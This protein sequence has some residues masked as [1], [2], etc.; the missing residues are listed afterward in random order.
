MDNTKNQSGSN[1]YQKVV[2]VIISCGIALGLAYFISKVAFDE[3]LNKVDIISTPNEK[4]RLVSRIS[5]DILQ[6]DQVQRAQVLNQKDYSGFVNESD[7][8]LQSLDTLKS[9]YSINSLQSKRI[10]SIRIL[11]NERDKLF[12]SYIQVRKN[13]VDNQA[14]SNQI[15]NIS[16]L[17]Q[18]VPKS[19][20]IITTEKKITT[21]TIES[22]TEVDNRGFF[23]KLFGVKSKPE[24]NEQIDVPQTV[25]EELN[26]KIDTIKSERYEN[27]EARIDQAIQDLEAKQRQK[28]A[29]FVN[30]ETELTL[31]GNILVSDMF[32][33]LHEVE[34]E[35]MHQM[36]AENS[37]ARTVVNQSVR[38][39]SFILLSFFLISA[40]LIYFILTDLRKGTNYR[41]ALENAK[42]AAEYHGAAKQRFLSNMSHELRTPLQSIIGY[43]EQLNF[44]NKDSDK[45]NVIY[46]SSQHLLQIVNEVLDY[47]RINSGKFNFQKEVINLQDLADEVATAMRPQ[48]KQKNIELNLSTR[49]SGNGLV[50]GDAFRLKQIL[51]N[52]VGNAIKFTDKGEVLLQITS[53][54]YGENT[55]IN[56]RIQDTGSGIQPED[57]DKI[58]DE[59]EQST[60]SDS[61]THFGN[62]LGLSIVKTLVKAMNGQIEVKSVLDK[63]S[64]FTVTFSLPT[65]SVDQITS[66]TLP[67]LKPASSFK[68]TV[69]LIDDDSFILDLCHSILSKYGIDHKCFQS[70]KEALHY[71]HN[72][73]LSHIF[74]DM[75]MP[76]INGKDLYKKLREKYDGSVKIIAFTAQALPEERKDIL[77]FGFDGLLLKPFKEANLLGALGVLAPSNEITL[78]E[79]QRP[80]DTFDGMNEDWIIDLFTNDTQKDLKELHDSFHANNFNKS[81]LLVHRM[82]GRTAQMGG[83]HIAFKLRKMEIDLRNGESLALPQIIEIDKLLQQFIL[84]IHKKEMS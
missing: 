51:F 6:I 73:K 76:E 17:I 45:I 5:R 40:V 63:G 29:T 48:A 25:H 84:D 67:A 4:L 60:K 78:N 9:L 28:S 22:S 14:F 69:W 23:A 8:I 72:Q 65:S 34:Q 44:A 10:D 81:E 70:P 68:D 59:F 13:L 46:Q 42:N 50:L 30:H 35:A 55:D 49:I 64:V 58:F 12:N 41:L 62:G 18:E 53:T 54:D 31:A 19:D 26:V 83:D 3:M 56:Y 66:P 61:G 15:R 77:T 43:A 2:F 39:I 20:K 21:K 71:P 11:L 38:R 33:I 52:L 82:A 7:F 16:S 1:V 47:N 24:S 79:Y 32:N 75:R 36:E 37:E 80:E 27:T 74:T 57:I